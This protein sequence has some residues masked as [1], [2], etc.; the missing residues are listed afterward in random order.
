[1]DNR[2]LGVVALEDRLKP[3]FTLKSLKLFERNVDFQV[4]ETHMPCLLIQEGEDNIIARSKRKG[5]G[6]PLTRQLDVIVEVWHFSKDAVR[7]LRKEVILHTFEGGS[8][9]LQSPRVMIEEH[10]DI[11]PFNQGI[12]GVLGRQ[13]IFKMTYFDETIT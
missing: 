12:P 2:E 9:L 13:V 11:G 1:M 4:T 5:S 10:K 6:Y 3:I 7:D 8:I